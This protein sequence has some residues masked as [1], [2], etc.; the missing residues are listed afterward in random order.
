MFK[1]DEIFIKF[2]NEARSRQSSGGSQ[3]AISASKQK[4]DRPNPNPNR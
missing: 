2:Q 1:L 3:T 4:I